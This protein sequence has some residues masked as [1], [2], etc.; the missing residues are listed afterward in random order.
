[1]AAVVGFVLG[2]GGLL[3]S[4][5]P[6]G[7]Q[8][9]TVDV[10]AIE[11]EQSALR[12]DLNALQSEVSDLTLPDLAPLNARLDA[13]DGTLSDLTAASAQG[14]PQSEAL[15]A[16]LAAITERLTALEQRPVADAGSPEAIAAVDAQLKMLQDSLA[17]QRA[18]VEDMMAEARQ[19]DAASAEAARI[20]SAQT[21]LARMRSALDSGSGYSA[22][23]DELKAL[24]VTAPDALTAPA[25][26]GVAT[27]AALR[28]SFAPAAREALAAA[29]EETKGTGNVMDYI[30]RHL[31]ARSVA[32]RDGDDPDAILSRAGAAVDAGK[33]SDALGEL[34]ALPE[35][36]GAALSEWEAAAR[37]RVAAFSAAD[38]LSQS[39]NAK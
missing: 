4:V 31:G 10:A 11:A 21:V 19:M 17:A 1:V 38:E 32:P 7:L 33:I 29:R 34:E 26:S 13:L 12:S 15:E 39:L 16:Q 30:K 22:L 27:L 2:Q 35:T 5:L 18:E 8:S 14:A 20:A 24:D 23:I 37:A 28:D 36:A 6:S 3:H 25:D 9:P